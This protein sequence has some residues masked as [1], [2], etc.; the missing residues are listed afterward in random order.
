[1]RNHSLLLEGGPSF[2]LRGLSGCLGCMRRWRLSLLGMWF[3]GCL[4]VCASL[5]FVCATGIV[6]NGPMQQCHRG[7][8][9]HI[10]SSARR[11]MRPA[12]TSV[13]EHNASSTGSAERALRGACGGEDVGAGAARCGHAP[14]PDPASVHRQTQVYSCVRGRV[15][16][17]RRR[18]AHVCASVHAHMCAC[19]CVR[20]AFQSLLRC[21]VVLCR[22]QVGSSFA[23]A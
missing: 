1:M 10:L 2:G 20:V 21:D 19:A 8:L 13:I 12:Q 14:P 17:A 11:H 6:R 9:I 22:S 15:V 16:G 23:S 7:S 5:R 4:R 18:Q 3:V